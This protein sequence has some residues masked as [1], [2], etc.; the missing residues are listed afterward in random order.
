VG[1]QKFGVSAEYDLADDKLVL[2]FGVLVRD[3]DG[4][5]EWLAEKHKLWVYKLRK[6]GRANNI[7]CLLVHAIH[8]ARI[9]RGIWRSGER[10]RRRAGKFDNG[11]PSR[12]CLF[13]ATFSQGIFSAS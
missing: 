7:I 1:G 6:H 8:R 10:W 12:A 9:C 5:I 3:G 13:E 11:G 2:V 4:G